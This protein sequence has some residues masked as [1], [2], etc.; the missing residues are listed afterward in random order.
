MATDV[1]PPWLMALKAY[2][3]NKQ[4]TMHMYVHHTTVMEVYKLH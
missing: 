2:S 4:E 1:S 3:A